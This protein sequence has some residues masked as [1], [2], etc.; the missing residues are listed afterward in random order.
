MP[1]SAP[2]RWST[3]PR[4]PGGYGIRPYDCGKVR[5]TTQTI[6]LSL[7]YKH[8]IQAQVPK[9]T[10]YHIG[11]EEFFALIGSEFVSMAQCS[12]NH[13]N[14]FYTELLFSHLHRFQELFVLPQ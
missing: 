4:P 6:S 14:I 10:L 11:G 5:K 8:E 2:T 3:H 13:S 7:F 12:L 1:T 9:T